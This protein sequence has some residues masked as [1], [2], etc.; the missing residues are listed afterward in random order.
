MRQVEYA[1]SPPALTHAVRHFYA[2]RA[3]G[4]SSA[5]PRSSRGTCLCPSFLLHHRGQ[6]EG[7]GQGS[8]RWLLISM[9]HRKKGRRGQVIKTPAADQS[10]L[11]Y[12]WCPAGSRS[13]SGYPMS[14]VRLVQGARRSCSRCQGQWTVN[15]L[16]IYKPTYVYRSKSVQWR[17]HEMLILSEPFDAIWYIWHLIDVELNFLQ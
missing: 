2:R 17:C 13:S 14:D 8:S 1:T 5:S 15:V 4:Q 6:V 12:H 3:S 10:H 9:E 16:N 7:Q 11:R